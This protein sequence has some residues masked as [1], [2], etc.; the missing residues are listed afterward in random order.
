MKRLRRALV[1]LLVLIAL[2]ALWVAWRNHSGIAI[3]ADAPLDASPQAVAR[4]AY[5]ARAGNCMHCHTSAGNA[6]WA[7]GRE[8]ATPF[9]SVFTPNLTPHV[10][11]GLGRWNA[12]QFWRAMHH[13][14]SADG[15]LL[16]PVFPY[17]SYTR[18]T[19]ED[20]DALFAYLRSLPAAD[21]PNR[22]SGLRWPY[23]QQAA[24]A[25]WRALFFWPGTYQP[26][27]QQSAAWNR[28]AYLVQGMGHCADCHAP[29]NAWG[30]TERSALMPGGIIPM[31]NWYAPS[32]TD[33]AEAGVQR[34]PAA[35]VVALLKTGYAPQATVSGPM[36]DV[37][38]HSTQH[39]S[40]DDLRAMATYLQ[41]L[42]VEQ[43]P[44]R[45]S[46]SPIDAGILARGSATYSAQCMHCHGAQGQGVADAYPALAG[47]RG[48]L[49]GEVANLVEQTLRGG[50]APAT[51]ANPRPFGMP[52]F[53]LT[54]SDQEVAEVLT[55]VRNSWGNQAPAVTELDVKRVRF[56]RAGP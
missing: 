53:M 52:P 13:G 10:E 15:R 44:K 43:L 30:A 45:A 56:G 51:A 25:V 41:A 23:D 34:W 54:L 21:L 49:M 8:L 38:Q 36:R 29:R 26:D 5:L 4:G 17:T 6:A 39:L 47:N 42:P 14:Q 16:Y 11:H 50:F 28:G 22:A 18:M 55:H 7:G 46:T 37:V 27:A 48:V 12:D 33:P 19:R 35:D 31:Q 20:S 1:W 40:D 24:L 9:G 2:A 32:L 3:R